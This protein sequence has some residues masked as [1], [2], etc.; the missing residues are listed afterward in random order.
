MIDFAKP[1][2]LPR[3]ASIAIG[4]PDR[5]CA[6]AQG[7]AADPGVER[8]SGR[9]HRLDDG[10]TLHVAQLAPVQIAVGLDSLRPAQEDVA[11]GL[12]HALPLDHPFTRLGVAA[13]GQVVLEHRGGRFL[14]LQEQRILLV[15]ALEQDDERSGADAADPD[16]LA[17]HVD[18]LE[19]LQK[20]PP[21][22]LQG[23]AVRAELLVDDTLE[24]I[25]RRTDAR[26]EHAQ[27]YDDRRLIDDPVAAVDLLGEL[28]QRL[29]AV[30]AAAPCP[31]S[32]RRPSW[33]SWPSSCRRRASEN[34]WRC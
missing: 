15:A 27:R 18:D 2:L 16:H 26:G 34:G 4:S 24:L 11:G 23:V 1:F 30:T 17:G 20:R 21:V 8:E 28:R 31:C 5:A 3:Y 12:H 25:D 22:I 13:L 7:P 14:D 19:A 33:L 10:R 29:Q 9:R 32:S 6:R